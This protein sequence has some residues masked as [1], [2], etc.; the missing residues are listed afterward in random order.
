VN[1]ASTSEAE[2]TVSV[3]CGPHPPS[4]AIGG[5][6][7]PTAATP[8]SGTV[9]NSDSK[10]TECVESRRSIAPSSRNRTSAEVREHL[11]ANGPLTRG[12]I[13]A[14]LGGNAGAI[15]KKLKRLLAKD[16][17]RA[18]GPPRKRL[19]SSAEK[20]RRLPT[21]A[22]A[23]R[24]KTRAPAA[25]ERGVYPLYD[26]IGDLNGATTA[27]LAQQTGLPRKLVVEQGQRLLKL[28]LV[29]FRGVGRERI[30]LTTQLES[31]RDAA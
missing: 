13:V 5:G 16:E 15:D 22:T 4:A 24:G 25:P 31:E 12:E 30:W 1:I 27:R 28:G 29:R 18:E 21:S 3:T 11:A 9:A 20:P 7:P 26:A 6:D 10:E 2:H 19:Y 17:I 14:D 23:T 8:P